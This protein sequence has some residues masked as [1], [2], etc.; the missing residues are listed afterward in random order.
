MELP[1][2]QVQRIVDEIVAWRKST[3]FQIDQQR[4]GKKVLFNHWFCRWTNRV[5]SAKYQPKEHSGA[6]A[7]GYD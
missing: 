1:E 7:Q 5:C 3:I 2:Q 4:S 6:G